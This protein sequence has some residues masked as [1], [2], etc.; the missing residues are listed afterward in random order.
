MGFFSKD[1]DIKKLVRSFFPLCWIWTNNPLSPISITSY[2]L[3]EPVRELP[4]ISKVL[5]HTVHAA[6]SSGLIKSFRAHITNL[7]FLFTFLTEQYSITRP[8]LTY[9]RN[10]EAQCGNSLNSSRVLVLISLMLMMLMMLMS[11]A[12]LTPMLLQEGF[13]FKHD[14]GPESGHVVGDLLEHYAEFAVQE[15]NPT[16]WKDLRRRREG[17]VYGCIWLSVVFTPTGF[18]TRVV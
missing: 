1:N 3:T 2:L 8:I 4:F 9:F 10:H 14:W 17:A 6:K 13:R 16:Y 11:D 18:H 15:I 12:D 5:H 7:S